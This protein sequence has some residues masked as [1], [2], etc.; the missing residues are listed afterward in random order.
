MT[1][2]PNAL[3]RTVWPSAGISGTAGVW[4]DV[5]PAGISLVGTD[6]GGDNYG[7][8]DVLAHPVTA[9]TFYAF[10]CYQGVWKSLDYGLTWTKV[11]AAAGVM[12]SGKV[13]GSAIAPDGTYMLATIG[14][15]LFPVGGTDAQLQVLRSTDGGATW[16]A[17][18][19]SLGYNPYNVDIS[20][21]DGTHCLTTGHDSSIVSESIDSGVTWTSL[22]QIGTTTELSRYVE[23]L[24]DT[25]ALLISQDGNADGTYIGA[26]S[27]TWS[28]SGKNVVSTNDHE[29]GSHQIFRDTVNG[30]RLSPG[31]NG[32]EKSTASPWTSWASASAASTPLDAII[33]TPTTLY[34]NRSF[35]INSG[36][37]DPKMQTA[38]R[39]PGTAW[40]LTATP[41]GMINGA[42]RFAVGTDGSRYVVVGG[43]WHAGIWRYIE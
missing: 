8:Q 10:T 34:A 22:G 42:K 27:G 11:S 21:T 33:G 4:T 9:G 2:Y 15:S 29:H 19:S 23:F 30:V 13:W 3:R 37:L 39:N 32:I 16:T 18:G 1:V 28:W 12:D 41:G 31:S 36:S 43:C 38:P 26:K 24:D 14:N 7:V 25:H 20:P 6:N 17:N 40:T 5:T 35:P